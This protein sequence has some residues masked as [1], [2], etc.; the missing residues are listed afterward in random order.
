M[1]LTEKTYVI[2]D[3]NGMLN[4]A[5]AAAKAA[6]AAYAANYYAANY[7]A[8]AAAYAATYANG[9]GDENAYDAN[10]YGAYA[11][12]SAAASAANYD[13]L[14]SAYK[15]KVDGIVRAIVKDYKTDNEQ[16]KDW[17]GATYAA[18]KA[19]KKMTD[20]K[21]LD[22]EAKLKI[23][24]MAYRIAQ[25]T[26]QHNTDDSNKTAKVSKCQEI[27]DALQEVIDEVYNDKVGD[28]EQQA[29][30]TSKT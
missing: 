15:G 4:A 17:L 9:K 30:E 29:S 28:I 14:V 6:S 21:G 24:Y 25:F 22:L 16:K 10:S 12:A 7:A 11:A 18:V 27:A 23:A 2:V 13:A 26:W 8:S 20:K 5:S 19:A 3:I 1:K